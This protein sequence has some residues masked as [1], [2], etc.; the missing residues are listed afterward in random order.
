MNNMNRLTKQVLVFLLGCIVFFILLGLVGRQEYAEQV[1]Y[2]M[3]QEAYEQIIITLGDGASNVDIAE[4]YM[5]NKEFY[6]NLNK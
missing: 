4:E 3:P 6:D 1:V 2:T 5:K